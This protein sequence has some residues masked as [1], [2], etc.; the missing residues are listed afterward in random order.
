MNEE[1][2]LMPARSRGQP[3][4]SGDARRAAMPIDAIVDG[5]QIRLIL[6]VL[7]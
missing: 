5:A 1:R 4:R 3:E 6:R 2:W 7:R